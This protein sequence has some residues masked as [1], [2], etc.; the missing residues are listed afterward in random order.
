ML[1]T[2]MRAIFF[3]NIRIRNKS[4]NLYWEVI[5][6]YG[7]VKHELKGQFLSEL[8]KKKILMCH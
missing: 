7:P 6:V 2:W 1:K 5:N 8:Y 4:D 3:S